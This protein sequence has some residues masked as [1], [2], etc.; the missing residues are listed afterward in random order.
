MSVIKKVLILC[1]GNTCRSPMAEGLWNHFA[2][3]R[4]QAQSAG[5]NPAGWVHPL[6]IEALAEIGIDISDAASKSVASFVDQPFD[7]VV[8]VCDHAKEVC[9]VF[10]SAK[11]TL[12]W[13]FEDPIYA[14]GTREQQ[15]D[16]F[17]AVRDRIKR[18]IE[19]YL[20]DH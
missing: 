3:G 13:P 9:P 5:S 11:E 19:T 10:P 18:R 20:A 4:W 2:A 12:H 6:A 8:T 15:M 14:S 17:R 16:E 1:T 7:L